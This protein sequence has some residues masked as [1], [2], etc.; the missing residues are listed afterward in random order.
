MALWPNGY[1][2]IA[3]AEVLPTVVVVAHLARKAT[4]APRVQG[5][6]QHVAHVVL[7]RLEIGGPSRPVHVHALSLGK[8]LEVHEANQMVEVVVRQEHTQ[9]VV[10]PQCLDSKIEVCDASSSIEH[11]ELV[12]CLQQKAAGLLARP[13]HPPGTAQDPQRCPHARSP[14]AAQANFSFRQ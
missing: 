10:T 5:A 12:C 13:W 3:H 9:A 11:D 14:L 2:Q 1:G 6:L 7:G 4:G 8:P